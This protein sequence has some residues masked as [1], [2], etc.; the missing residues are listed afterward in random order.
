MA[1]TAKMCSS[2]FIIAE[3]EG[4]SNFPMSYRRYLPSKQRKLPYFCRCVS[5][6]AL[7]PLGGCD[8][9]YWLLISSSVSYSLDFYE[10]AQALI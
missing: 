6:N 1:A 5:K 3:M 7:M 9:K 4:E 10:L 8:R 2:R